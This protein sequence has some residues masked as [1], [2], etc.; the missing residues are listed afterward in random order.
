LI[1][2]SDPFAIDA[3]LCWFMGFDPHKVPVVEQRSRFG[4]KGWGQFKLSELTAELDGQQVK[5]L[6]TKVN[7]NFVPP[8]AWRTWIER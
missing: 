7:F 4:G 5:V 2:G 6:E 3:A 1:C 8:P